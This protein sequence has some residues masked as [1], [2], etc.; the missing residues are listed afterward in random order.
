M[1]RKSG[2]VA[3]VPTYLN[4]RSFATMRVFMVAAKVAWDTH[5]S[6]ATDLQHPE[7]A[8]THQLFL[9]GGGWQDEIARTIQ[10]TFYETG[11]CSTWAWSA[12]R[13]STSST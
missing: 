1:Q 13:N 8:M 7:Q 11:S 3:L 6:K 4:E 9:A 5:A 10:H 2:T 12:N